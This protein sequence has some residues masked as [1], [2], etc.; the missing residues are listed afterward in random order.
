MLLQRGLSTDAARSSPEQRQKVVRDMN[1]SGY[2]FALIGGGFT[3]I[4]ALLGQWMA[5]RFS[6]RLHKWLAKQAAGIKLSAASFEIL[7]RVE[8]QTKI[9]GVNPKLVFREHFPVQQAAAFAFESF[10]SVRDRLRFRK[11]WDEHRRKRNRSRRSYEAIR[12]RGWVQTS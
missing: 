5:Y 12:R 8:P 1:L 6:T 3:I 11:A 10:L 9:G 7:A 2:E 4:G